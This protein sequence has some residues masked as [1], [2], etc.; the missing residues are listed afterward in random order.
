MLLKLVPHEKDLGGGFKVKRLLP[1]L[2]RRSVGPFVFF[3]HFGPIDLEPGTNT[4]VRPHPHILC[5][6]LDMISRPSGVCATS[7]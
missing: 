5:T 4:D 3:D 6:K 2:E 7:G 1:A